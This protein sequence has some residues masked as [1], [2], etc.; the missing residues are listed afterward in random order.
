MSYQ[1]S[2]RAKRR[3]TR[4]N[5]Q[6]KKKYPLFEVTGLLDKEGWFTTAMQEEINLDKIAASL[7]EWQYQQYLNSQEDK[8][9]ANSL[10]NLCIIHCGDKL[11]DLD[12]LAEQYKD[13]RGN[14]KWAYI[15]DIYTQ[16]LA[17]HYQCL[18]C[19]LSFYVCKELGL[20]YQCKFCQAEMQPQDNAHCPS[21]QKH[22]GRIPWHLDSITD[23]LAIGGA[24]KGDY[25]EIRWNSWAD[26][27]AYFRMS[28]KKKF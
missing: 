8:R 5:N 17:K 4:K 24:V 9:R 12:R 26:I 18:P 11:E 27:A 22:V 2:T 21:C 10:R 28:T 3:A 6:L 16:P 15:A 23:Y 25:T 7:E 19:H 14:D 13:K 1:P 20:P